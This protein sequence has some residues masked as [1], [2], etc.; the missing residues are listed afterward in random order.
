MQVMTVTLPLS[1][2]ALIVIASSQHGPEGHLGLPSTGVPS[3]TAHDHLRGPAAATS[4][5]RARGE[6]ACPA[7]EPSSAELHAL[8]EVRAALRDLVRGDTL[9]YERRRDRLLRGAVYRLSGPRLVPTGS[10]WARFAT[11]LLPALVAVSDSRARLGRCA[12]QR[13]GWLFLDRSAGRVR[14]WCDMNAC[15]N[16]VK[17]RRFRARQRGARAQRS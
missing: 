7:G 3:A 11:G 8:R 17:A 4:W 14:R 9:A 10:G 13:C 1:V 5:L 15:G 6:F 16:R 2:E 12:N